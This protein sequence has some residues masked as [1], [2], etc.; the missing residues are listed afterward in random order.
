MHPTSDMLGPVPTVLI[1]WVLTVT[2]LAL[3][4]TS[5]WRLVR[6]L[7]A[8]QRENR[9]DD[10]LDRLVTLVLHVFGHGRLLRLLLGGFLRLLGF[11]FEMLERP[12]VV[13]CQQARA[14]TGKE[15][16][17][18]RAWA[19][20]QALEQIHVHAFRLPDHG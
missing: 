1:L 6:L 17:A 10:P 15:Q 16:R 9:L 20:L 8:G 3:F 7:R 11:G 14:H 19:D 12:C 18:H 2:A 4:A 5:A 13:I